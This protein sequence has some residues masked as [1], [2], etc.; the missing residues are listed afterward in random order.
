MRKP[1]VLTTGCLGGLGDHLVYST[2]PE[3]YSALGFDVYLDAENICR[4]PDIY[5]LVWAKNP[6]IVG[7]SDRKPAIG[8]THQGHFYDVANR[9][10][11][12]SIEAMERAHQLEPPYSLAPR[13]Y[14]EPQPFP[15]DLRNSV[16]VDYGA[17][18]STL[19]PQ[20]LNEMQPKMQDRFGSKSFYMVTFPSGVAQKPPLEGPSIQMNGI[21]QYV[22]ALASCAAWVGSEAG[23]QALAAA[24][25]GEY[26]AY[27]MD[28]HPEVVCV[29]STMTYNSRGYTFRG[30]DYRVTI[31]S[32]NSTHDYFTPHE[33]AYGRYQA[34]CRRS[35]EEARAT[36]DA[37]RK[38]EEAALAE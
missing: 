19:A 14:Y 35:V 29:I 38:A 18:S 34:L 4:N 15:I 16:L 23:G 26:D 9:L 36:W 32:S 10:P 2:L 8:Y 20:A 3:R 22:D 17:V 28:V 6:Y 21:F 30:V 1:I 13:I 12:G 37:E 27:R 11:I 7:T 24:V 5:D 33:V 25:R 31:H